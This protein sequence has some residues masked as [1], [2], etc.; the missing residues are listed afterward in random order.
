MSLRRGLSMQ[1]DI[2]LAEAEVKTLS[3]DPDYDD[4]HEVVARHPFPRKKGYLAFFLV[5]CGITFTVTGLSTWLSEALPLNEVL[6]FFIMGGLALAPGLYSSVILLNAWR[7][8]EGWSYD[9]LPDI[10]WM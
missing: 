5:V 8:M 7:G 10:D 2:L 1:E 9:Q 3:D 4:E 6:P